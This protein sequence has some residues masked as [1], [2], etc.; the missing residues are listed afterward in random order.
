MVHIVEAPSVTADQIRTEIAE[1]EAR[2]DMSSSTFIERYRAGELHETP[3]FLEW[4]SLLQECAIV[5]DD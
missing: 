1:F 2:F 4:E 3:A 5:C